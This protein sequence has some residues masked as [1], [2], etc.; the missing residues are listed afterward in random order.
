MIFHKR[1]AMNFFTLFATPAANFILVIG[2][3]FEVKS[4]M[5]ICGGCGTGADRVEF[6]V[7]PLIAMV[8]IQRARRED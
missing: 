1:T 4:V 5:G 2:R 3:R 6:Y 7:S 8:S